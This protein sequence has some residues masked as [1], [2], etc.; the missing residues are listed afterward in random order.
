MP[1]I[2]PLVCLMLVLVLGASG[3]ASTVAQPE[4]PAIDCQSPEFFAICFDDEQ[5]TL[6]AQDPTAEAPGTEPALTDLEDGPILTCIEAGLDSDGDGLSGACEA[7]LG[8]DP[9]NWDTDSD[10]FSDKIERDIGRDPLVFTNNDDTVDYGGFANVTVTPPPPTGNE[11]SGCANP[12]FIVLCL[13]D[14]GPLISDVVDSDADGTST[15]AIAD[16]GTSGVIQTPTPSS[17]E[18]SGDCESD[19]VAICYDDGP[20]MLNDDIDGD[21]LAN[22]REDWLGTDPTMSDSGLG[23]AGCQPDFAILCVQDNLPVLDG[24]PTDF[25]AVDEAVLGCNV[26][27]ADSDGDGLPDACEAEQGSDPN[28]PDTDGDGLTDGDEVNTYGMFPKE[29]DSDGDGLTDYEEA[30]THGTSPLEQDSDADCGGDGEEVYGGTNPLSQDSDGDG[31]LDRVDREPANPA[32]ASLVY[33]G[34]DWCG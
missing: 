18:A 20:V 9:A 1:R 8:T 4:R 19:F 7:V 16:G 30:M 14:D 12:A 13:E 22:D 23:A 5:V 3:P 24:T 15:E 27:V 6:P 32:E 31:T 10:G 26:A 21:G 25:V 28:D 11:P 33:E 34:F 2:S 29:P 17:G